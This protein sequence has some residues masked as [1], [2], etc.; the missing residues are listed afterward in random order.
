MHVFVED[1]GFVLGGA[2]G[3]IIL[4][5]R[6]LLKAKLIGLL[7]FHRLRFW[8]YVDLF[9]NGQFLLPLGCERDIVNVSYLFL[10]FGM[11]LVCV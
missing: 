6:F 9:N 7:L 1:G 8:E 11:E 4:R 10:G 2:T 5:H 3:Q